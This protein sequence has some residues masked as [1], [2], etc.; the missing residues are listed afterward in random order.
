MICLNIIIGVVAAAAY[1][2]LL[3]KL[4]YGHFG[5]VWHRLHNATA[6]KPHKHAILAMA[7]GTLVTISILICFIT[8]LGIDSALRGAIFGAMCAV[9]FALPAI[10]NGTMYQNKSKKIIFID[11]CF[12]LLA[13]TG[14]STILAVLH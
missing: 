12:E 13:I 9:A 4:W 7:I 2:M 1:H 3:G 6:V 11:G 14:M 5:H 8:R 10:V